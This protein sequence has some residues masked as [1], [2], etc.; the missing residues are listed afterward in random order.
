LINQPSTRWLDDRNT[1][2]SQRVCMDWTDD[3]GGHS[4]VGASGIMWTKRLWETVARMSFG[5]FIG[6]LVLLLILLYSGV[7]IV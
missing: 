5:I 7:P 1:P 3:S 6:S 4:S 2:R